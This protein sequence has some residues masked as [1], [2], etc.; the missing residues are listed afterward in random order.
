MSGRLDC[1]ISLIEPSGIIADVG[2]DHGLVAQYCAES[3]IAEKVIA[4]DISE[5]CLKKAEDLLR[6]ADNVE[7]ICCD[8]I[9][10]YCDEAII[11]GMGGILIS[12]I[13]RSAQTLPNTVIAVP[14]RD[15][16]TL[17]RTL[18]ELGYGIDRDVPIWDKDKF[19]SVI[20]AKKCG[21]VTR[22]T[23]LQIEFGAECE[24]PSQALSAYLI[25]LR[26]TYMRAPHVNAERLKSVSA[27]LRLQGV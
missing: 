13:L 1:I 20:R 12:E 16:G 6:D 18:L 4:S 10:Y 14:H 24:I 25:K 9:R 8:G 2:C 3:G 5:K 26:D 11:S 7:F 21:G 23:E 19:Y 17:R 22:L 27:A 15:G